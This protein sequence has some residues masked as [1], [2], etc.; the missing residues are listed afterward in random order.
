MRTRMTVQDPRRTWV[1]RVVWG[2]A[3]KLNCVLVKVIVGRGEWGDG[4]DETDG[5]TDDGNVP[6]R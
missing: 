6:A 4:D 3:R 1:K 2:G 5:A